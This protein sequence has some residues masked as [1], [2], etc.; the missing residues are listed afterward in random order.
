MAAR[1]V[2]ATSAAMLGAFFVSTG[3][4]ATPASASGIRAAAAA[5][6]LTESVVVVCRRPCVG[7]RRVCYQQGPYA[8]PYAYPYGYPGYYYGPGVG[9]YGPGVSVGIGVGPRW[10]W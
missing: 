4:E 10:G 7:C 5:T 1:P 6:D 9:V 2:C 8:Y 3:A